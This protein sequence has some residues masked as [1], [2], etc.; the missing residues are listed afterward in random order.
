MVRIAQK[1]S[2]EHK[3]RIARHPVSVGERYD[4]YVR[5]RDLLVRQL[6]TQDVSKLVNIGVATVDD[7]VCGFA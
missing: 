3:I 1:P 7:Y 5:G 2:V 4:L 6:A